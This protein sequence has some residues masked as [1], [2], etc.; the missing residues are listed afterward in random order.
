MTISP[1]TFP[2]PPLQAPLARRPLVSRDLLLVGRC[3]PPPPGV[4]RGITYPLSGVNALVSAG[5]AN[6]L[7]SR[8]CYVMT[9]RVVAPLV[10]M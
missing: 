2:T 1:F 9:G 7:L 10:V 5:L 4:R 6:G 3:I 8:C